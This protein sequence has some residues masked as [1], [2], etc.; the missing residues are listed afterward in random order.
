ML[1]AT[2]KLNGDDFG[3]EKP[4]QCAGAFPHFSLIRRNAREVTLDHF[5]QEAQPRPEKINRTLEERRFIRAHPL[6]VA[7]VN[8]L[9]VDA[10]AVSD[11]DSYL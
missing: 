1:A 4:R 8:K 2:Y 10:Q 9:C 3:T 11:S 5:P 6:G 7:I